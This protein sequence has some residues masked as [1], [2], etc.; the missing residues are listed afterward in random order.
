MIYVSCRRDFRSD[1]RFSE[2]NLVRD[3]HATLAGSFDE[4]TDDALA[5]RA[6]GKHVLVLVHGYRNPIKTVETAYRQIVKTLTE[7]GLLTRSDAGLQEQYGLA[8]GFAWPGF[9]T[10]VV[11]FVAARPSANRAGGYLRDLL[12]VLQ[13]SARTVDVQT[14]SLGARVALQA[15][16]TQDT[17]WVD[18]LL[19]TA[20]A[21][22]NECLEPNE[23]FHEA[24]D[25]CARAFVY[26]SRHD[27][28]LK[29]YS[30]FAADRALGATGPQN[31]PVIL[32]RCPNVYVV[33]CAVV[34]GH[35]DYRKEKRYF[36]HWERVLNQEPLDRY[37]SI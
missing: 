25:S 6:E 1:H 23:E 9:R 8:I 21:V 33:D 2:R 29:A 30:A 35:S 32:E 15:L 37:G 18:N 7:R 26:H 27:R 10:R 36:D 4:L 19:I 20:P 14:H 3:Y 31:K 12:E 28:V 5:A 16:S 24:L 11:G 22:D 34:K 17:L 13:R